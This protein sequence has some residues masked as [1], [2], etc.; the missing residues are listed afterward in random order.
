LS[1]A[2]VNDIGAAADN[3]AA[4]VVVYPEDKDAVRQAFLYGLAAGR[5]DRAL[6]FAERLAADD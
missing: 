5:I 4:A 2:G 6:P 1:A 3:Y